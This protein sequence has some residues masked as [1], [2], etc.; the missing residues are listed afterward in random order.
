MYKW[1]KSAKTGLII[2]LGLYS[3]LGGE[4]LGKTMESYCEW[5]QSFARIPKKEYEKLVSEFNPC[6]FDCEELAKFACK[7]GYKYII[8]TA[9]HHDGFCL[10]NSSYDNF[11]I[12]NTP[13]KKDLIQELSF[14]CKKYDIKFGVY[15]S[16]DLDWHEFNGG[17]Y[18]SLNSDCAGTSWC[19]NWDFIDNSRK[20][21]NKY[22]KEKVLTQI[23]ELCVNYGK[24]DIFWFDTPKT[25]TPQQSEEIYNLVKKYQPE[26]LINSRLGNGSYDYVTLGDNEIPKEI[27]KEFKTS[28]LNKLNGFKYSENSVYESVCTL[29]NSWGYS[30]NDCIF[31]SLD[32]IKKIKTRLNHLGINYTINIGPD[33]N[34]KIQSQSLY[35][36]EMLNK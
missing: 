6:Q 12:M 7:N 11:N 34:G 15:Y 31:K 26:C 36:L 22:F 33:G 27:P 5:I 13:Y 24:I 2:H 21:F 25:I 19:N 23:K 18:N 9:K 35:L 4:Y 30:K 20:D 14:S 3:I 16:Q 28:D 32:E 10:F 1:F 8:I 29:N 17:G